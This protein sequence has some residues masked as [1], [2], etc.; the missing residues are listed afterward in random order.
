MCL[1][2]FGLLQFNLTNVHFLGTINVYIEV[3][4]RD[5]RLV[6]DQVLNPLM[7]YHLVQI[8]RWIVVKLD[9]PI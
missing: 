2:I 8:K 9:I 3:Q 6:G 7:I 5:R 1:S 4:L